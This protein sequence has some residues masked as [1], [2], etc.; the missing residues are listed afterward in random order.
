MVTLRPLPLT[1]YNLTRTRGACG[2]Q[3]RSACRT[4]FPVASLSGGHMS[5]KGPPW[6]DSSFLIGVD[7]ITATTGHQTRELVDHLNLL[8][9]RLSRD[10][11][12]VPTGVWE[13]RRRN[14]PSWRSLPG[15]CIAWLAYPVRGSHLNR[16]HTM[17]VC[18]S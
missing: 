1:R 14:W 5:L 18:F 7:K 8:F 12:A 17:H 13:P 6:I 16:I 9:A 15:T 3:H 10:Q 2:H 4:D 11:L